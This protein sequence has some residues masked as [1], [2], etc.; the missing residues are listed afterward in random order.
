M[1]PT[2]PPK[3]GVSSANILGLCSLKMYFDMYVLLPVY[4]Y[5]CV[6]SEPVG[7]SRGHWIPLNWSYKWL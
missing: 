5:V 3:E 7:A 6:V 1:Q 4:V 2:K